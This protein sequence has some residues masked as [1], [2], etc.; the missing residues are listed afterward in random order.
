MQENP[1][2][3]P[4]GETPHNVTM[5]CY[6]EMVDTAKPGD[7]VTVTGIYKATALR[8]NPRQ[9]AL[10]VRSAVHTTLLVSLAALKKRLLMC[11]CRLTDTWVA[12]TRAH[13]HC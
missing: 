13:R 8:V 3:I 5:L 2:A 7:R 10:K 1:N 9:K 11:Y 6:D 12:I 4:E